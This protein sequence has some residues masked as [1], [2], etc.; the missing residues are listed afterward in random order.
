MF[1]IDRE[2][3]AAELRTVITRLVKK[4]RKKSEIGQQLSLTQRSTLATLYQKEM[5]P[6][7]LAALEKI[8]NQSMSQILNHLEDLELINRKASETDKR[9]VVVSIS[10]KG[11]DLLLKMREE[12]NHWLSRAIADTCAPQEQEILLK[13]IGPLTKLL[14]FE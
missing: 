9:K 1:S 10:D 6:S 5:L 4:L 8:T 7:E 14:D 13:A 12:R 2:F 11:T 3:L